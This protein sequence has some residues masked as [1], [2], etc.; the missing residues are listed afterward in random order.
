MTSAKTQRASAS[1]I[2]TDRGTPTNTPAKL[3]QRSGRAKVIYS[4]A[5]L[6]GKFPAIQHQPAPEARC[7]LSEETRDQ[8]VSRMLLV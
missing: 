8:L 2:S 6:V 3:P 4:R 5:E 7:R 1:M